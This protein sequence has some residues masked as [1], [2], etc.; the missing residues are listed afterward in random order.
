LFEGAP[1]DSL[2]TV[3]ESGEQR[4][5]NGARILLILDGHASHFYYRALTAAKDQGVVVLCLPAHL[6]HIIQP[7]DV[8]IFGAV[9]NEFR[10]QVDIHLEEGEQL[11]RYHVAALY[12]VA[13]EKA[14]TKK[15]IKAGYEQS[16]I[17]P[18]N[19]SKVLQGGE[20]STSIPASVKDDVDII[21]PL[22]S[23]KHRRV[24]ADSI[25]LAKMRVEMPNLVKVLDWCADATEQEE[26]SSLSKAKMAVQ[27][28]RKTTERIKGGA[29]TETE[30]KQSASATQAQAQSAQP[31]LPH[32]PPRPTESSPPSQEQ[33]NT[34]KRKQAPTEVSAAEDL[35]AQILHR[36]RALRPLQVRT[37]CPMPP[38]PIHP[39]CLSL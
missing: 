10:E 1:P 20:L 35:T 3:T 32:S 16:G 21:L 24:L 9:K 29:A 30:Q 11:S 25:K 4:R 36:S 7:L 12:S 13:R 26:M 23:P 34:K 18:F 19:P 6:T 39:Q 38:A 22:S 14:L 8:S 37:C 17:Y 15:T 28:A 31:A 33:K 5:K 2:I 27:D